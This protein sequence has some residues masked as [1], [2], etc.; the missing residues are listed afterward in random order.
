MEKTYFITFEGLDGCGKDT[1]LHKLVEQIREDDNHPFGN[2]Y[3]NVWITREPTKI[4][5]HGIAISEAIRE[6]DVS[7]EEATLG[8]TEDRKEH[9]KIIKDILKHSHVFCSRYDLSTLSYQMTQG[10][11]FNE[12]YD[13]HKFGEGEGCLVPDITLV[14]DVPVE[15]A[16]ERTANRA[17]TEEC[18]EKEEFQRELYGN[19]HK[20]IQLLKEKDKKRVILV[21]NANQAIEKVFEE[22]IRKIAEVL[23]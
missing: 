4:T 5:K 23:N 20:A 11:E 2:K 15:V 21:I 22:M 18:F 13:L 17:G 12:L 7:K 8:Y 14:F 9:T 10:M 19:L 1:Q 16:L 3:S 6:R